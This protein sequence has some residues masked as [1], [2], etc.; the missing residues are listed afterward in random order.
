ML[1]VILITNENPEKNNQKAE[2][3]KVSEEYYMLIYKYCRKKLQTNEAHAY[4]ATNDVFV[5][6]CE[7]WDSFHNK[8]NIRAWLHRAADNI[9]KKFH[10]KNKKIHRELKYIDDLDDFTANSLSYEQDFENISEDN[11]EVYRDEIL[12]ELNDRE[13]ELFDIV[14]TERLPYNEICNELSITKE[15]LKKQLYRLRQKINEAVF[16]KINR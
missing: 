7:K 1:F 3:E 13:R 15:N 11:I 14:F 12:N 5:L 4:D 6:L 16:E 10:S 9:I 2:L 8:D